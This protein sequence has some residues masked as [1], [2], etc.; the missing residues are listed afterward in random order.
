VPSHER[1]PVVFYSFR[2][3]IKQRNY[4]LEHYFVQS[5]L[6]DCFVAFAILAWMW[7]AFLVTQFFVTLSRVGAFSLAIKLVK[8]FR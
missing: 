6:R 7:A 4:E 8:A 1:V 5:P 2:W 3:Q